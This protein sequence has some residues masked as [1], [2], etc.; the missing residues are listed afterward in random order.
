M[1]TEPDCPSMPRAARSASTGRDMSWSPSR[2]VTRSNRP[3]MPGPEASVTAKV[4]RPDTPACSALRRGA[5][6]TAGARA[7]PSA[8]ARGEARAL[9]RRAPPPPPAR[10]ATAAGSAARGWVGA[11][12][13]VHVRD[14]GQPLCSQQV[15]ERGPVVLRPALRRPRERRRRAPG[16]ER[17]HELRQPPC[18][19]HDLD[20]VE[21]PVADVVEVDE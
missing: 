1:T 2:I 3:D 12:P 13:L 10:A 14:G 7:K 4:T 21:S 15:E 19:T 20:P 6:S 8:L 18:G 9:A 17:V 11:Q 16:A 5:A